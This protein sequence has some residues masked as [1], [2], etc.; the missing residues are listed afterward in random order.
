MGEQEIYLPNEDN[1]MPAGTEFSPTIR[2]AFSVNPN[3]VT[4]MKH[5]AEEIHFEDLCNE[6]DEAM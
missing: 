3:P 4:P 2:T 5:R 6:G 1:T